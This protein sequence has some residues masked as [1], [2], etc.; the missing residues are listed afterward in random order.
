M[1]SAFIKNQV[2]YPD[3]EN[4]GKLKRLLKYLKRAKHM[5]LTLL[6]ESVSMIMWWVDASYN[7]DDDCKGHTGEM[8]SLEKGDVL[9][10]SMKKKL[11]VRIST[12][13]N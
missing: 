5:K 3:E 11:N 12:E 4:W 6:V 13:G 1:D 2:K 9:S 7:A 8:M 10:K